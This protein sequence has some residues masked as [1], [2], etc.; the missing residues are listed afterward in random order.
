MDKA[1]ISSNDLG[2]N[3]EQ[4]GMVA[5]DDTNGIARSRIK[6]SFHKL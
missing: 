2:T 1:P 6:F 4:R 5:S 3:A